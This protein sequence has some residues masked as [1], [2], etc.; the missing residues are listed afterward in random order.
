MTGMASA[1]MA[2]DNPGAGTLHSRRRRLDAE[3]SADVDLRI[4]KL[5]QGSFFPGRLERRRVDQ[6]MS[7]VVIEVYVHG[8]SGR[9]VDD[10]VKALGAGTGI[11]KS[12]VSRICAGLD[13]DKVLLVSD[14][15]LA[16]DDDSARND[17]P[18]D[19]E[20]VGRK[21]SPSPRY[22]SCRRCLRW[23]RETR[24]RV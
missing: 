22:A 23:S 20:I 15:L 19:G 8:I 16:L 6:P 18:N 1:V 9:K 11:S 13:A 12:V 24:A 17:V 10:L 21:S 7:A 2:V 3:F 4:L 14:V 5:R